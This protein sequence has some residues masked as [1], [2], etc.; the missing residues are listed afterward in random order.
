MGVLKVVW[1]FLLAYVIISTAM[2]LVLLVLVF[3]HARRIGSGTI[4]RLEK[5]QVLLLLVGYALFPV[6]A[7]SNLMAIGGAF[8]HHGNSVGLPF[9]VLIALLQLSAFCVWLSLRTGSHR[10][11]KQGG[12]V[13]ILLVLASAVIPLSYL[14]WSVPIWMNF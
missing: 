13:V 10:V 7:I 8:S 6:Q 12:G 2:T 5:I 9:A 3:R 4:N 14:V 11:R 1:I